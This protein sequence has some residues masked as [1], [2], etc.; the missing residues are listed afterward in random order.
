M[1]KTNPF[2]KMFLALLAGVAL[3]ILASGVLVSLTYA[4]GPITV[5]TAVD[6]YNSD[7]D[8]SLREAIQAA[9]YN[10]AVDACTSG[11]V[12]ADVIEFNLPP[13]PAVITLTYSTLNYR[14]LEI[15][16][17]PLTINGPG[18]E[19]LAISGNDAARVFK[20]TSNVAVTLTGLTVRDGLAND[21]GNDGGGLK[22]IGPLTLIE[23]VFTNNHAN[24]DGGAIDV[25]RQVVLSNTLILSNT[26]AGD[27]GGINLHAPSTLGLNE[28]Q[29]ETNRET[30]LAAGLSFA[31]IVSTLTGGISIMDGSA[32]TST[33]RGG[34][35]ENNR[36]GVYAGAIYLLNSALQVTDTHFISN[37]VVG[38]N[39]YGGAVFAWNEV[40]ISG[41]QFISN[42][43]GNQAG[44]L[45]ALSEARLTDT[46]F[47]GNTAQTGPAGAL[48]GYGLLGLTR[49]HFIDNQTGTVG[50]AV[51]VE[52]DVFRAVN[53]LFARNRAPDAGG[54]LYL[55][56][57][58]NVDLLHNT[59]AGPGKAVKAAV[60]ISTSGRISVVN[61]IVSS[62]TTGLDII[63]GAGAEDYNLFYQTVPVSG[64]LT[65]G[66]HSFSGSPGFVDASGNDYHL[67]A[68][69]W[70][71]NRGTGSA[72][73]TDLDGDTRPGGGSIDIGFDETPHP[74][75][76]V[77]AKS[78]D[79]G[80]G[81]EPG[82]AITYTLTFSNAGGG[83]LDGVVIT[84]IIPALVEQI[85]VISSG[86]LITDTNAVTNFVWQVA[87]L[88]PNQTGVI[89]V[90]GVLTWR[91]PRGW[92]TNTTRLTIDLPP[93]PIT[94]NNVATASVFV[95]NFAPLAV[96]DVIT[97]AE[98]TAIVLN[99]LTND[100]D[101]DP[102]TIT[103]VGQ[104]QHGDISQ[105]GQTSLIYTPTLNF[106]GTDVFTY[107]VDDNELFDIG[108]IGMVVTPVNDAPIIT[109]TLVTVT[110]SEDSTPVAFA[111]TLTATDVEDDPL[112]WSVT[113][114]PQNGTAGVG[115]G[116][117]VTTTVAYTP[118]KDHSGYDSFI[119]QVSDGGLTDTVTVSVTIE[120]ANDAPVAV[121]D[122]VLVLNKIAS[123]EMLLL[124][125]G[126]VVSLTV[127]TN[128]TDAESTP[129]TITGAGLPDQGGAVSIAP[130]SKYLF[131]TPTTTFTGTETF[132]YTITDGQ[133]SDTGI[134]TATVLSGLNGGNNG[135]VFTVTNRGECGIITITIEIP[136]D[137]AGGEKLAV[138]YDEPSGSP[139]PNGG[140]LPVCNL[141]ELAAWLNSLPLEPPDFQKPLTLT[142]AYADS[143][144]STG[145][146]SV[147]LY[148]WDGAGWVETDISEVERDTAGDR[149]TLTLNQAGQFQLFKQTALYL[150][151][152]Q[153]N[154]AQAP[155]LVVQSLTATPD[156]VQ[157][158]IAN[159]GPV[160]VEDPFWVDVY[161][162]PNTPPTG[163]NQIWQNLGSQGLAWGITANVLPLARGEV[164]TLTVGDAW[165]QPDDSVVAWPVAEGLPVY[166][167]VDS[168]NHQTNYGAVLENHEITG[169]VYNNISTTQVTSSTAG[170]MSP[171]VRPAG[172]GSGVQGLPV[173]EY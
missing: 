69:S 26:A 159:I 146:S 41:A 5:N 170:G 30:Y 66:G 91:L 164:V 158:V 34:R 70:A 28:A 133:F 134:V 73:A 101:G 81:P 93:E 105:S 116:P 59:I 128:D 139:V 98:E 15:K 153:K 54:A 163:V 62:Y 121:D 74:T 147:S 110:M 52:G 152:L 36:A 119:V 107:V 4:A 161:L 68:A 122:P 160:P 13:T 21:D 31:E 63:A 162:N 97:T 6:E 172:D 117:A 100:L 80:S 132:S 65:R 51:V 40:Q 108:V 56:T 29:L 48:Y 136:A 123:D 138:V 19:L 2:L 84:D 144:I 141:F 60:T 38:Q 157:V 148:R 76:A 102:L 131:Y 143:D 112:G 120:S 124:S 156:G 149:L 114:A 145:S 83:M 111:L 10:V 12:G 106:N 79:T 35:F 142:F 32:L 165:Y 43:V 72:I 86:A 78:V 55:D 96:D 115:S 33:I 89:T 151:V 53:S 58:G 71:I 95:P 11:T 42:T 1:K 47:Q 125:L 150:P 16:N 24:D 45:L 14:P 166:A 18:A 23:T 171:A 88:L 37:S 20:V 137:I 168:V 27:G 113:G 57:T 44:A 82:G 167:Q 64:S 94:A 135:D 99:P 25:T 103:A 173:R 118:T 155:D 3:P 90:S 92:F 129:L 9:N 140:L 77:I 61:N 7:G 39:S 127:L 46:H 126:P 109:P 8:C 22:S 50:G 87:P 104:P 154:Y 49:T 85:S 75:E 17:E 169:G 67:T 130:N